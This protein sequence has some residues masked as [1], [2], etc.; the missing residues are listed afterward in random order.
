MYC[1]CTRSIYEYT[2][3]MPQIALNDRTYLKNDKKEKQAWIKASK[4]D[5]AKTLSHWIRSILNKASL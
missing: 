3:T 2:T 4:R 5:K 1:Y